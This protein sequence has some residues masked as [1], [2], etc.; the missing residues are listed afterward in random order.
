V[1]RPAVVVLIWAG[2]GAAAQSQASL[3]VSSAMPLVA[4]GHHEGYFGCFYGCGIYWLL[5]LGLPKL[6]RGSLNLEVCRGC[7]LG[8]CC[9]LSTG[10]LPT[11]LEKI[12]I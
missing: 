10:C 2:C 3:A 1:P 12:M 8:P 7:A 11:G 5:L 6:Q 4:F 9:G